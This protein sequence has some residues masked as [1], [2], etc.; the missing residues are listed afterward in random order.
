MSRGKAPKVLDAQQNVVK[1]VESPRDREHIKLAIVC[2]LTLE[3]DAVH[4]LFDDYW[5]DLEPRDMRSSG[6]TNAYSFGIFCKFPIVLV[7]MPGMGK[8][9][10]SIVATNCRN[11][12]PNLKLAL[13]VG[14]CGG[15]PF[16]DKGKT[17][18]VLGDVIISEGLVP[19][20]YGRRYPDRFLRKDGASDVL[21]KPPTELRGLLNKLKGRF[22]RRKLQERTVSHLRTLRTELGSEVDYLGAGQ[23]HLFQGDYMHRHRNHDVCKVCSDTAICDTARSSTCEELSCDQGKLVVRERLQAILRDGTEFVP[24]VQFGHIACGDQVMKSGE[25]RDS[26]A[27]E[28]GV[29][30]FEMEGAGVW[31]IFPC[32]VIKAVCDYADSH[33]Q[34]KWQNY[35]AGTAAA[36]TKA[37]MEEWYM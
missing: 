21:G 27:K 8:T 16:T 12:F 20:D 13:V 4:A 30:A 22:G 7:H 24:V 2:A 26:I 17:E 3:A 14:I 1:G 34:K 31:D 35:A 33:K 23:D 18:I 32:L 37:L 25:H 5:E 9:S 10:A 36:C 29:I 28:E 6:D 15:V 19:Y 11:S